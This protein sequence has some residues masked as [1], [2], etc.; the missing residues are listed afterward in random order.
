MGHA[1]LAL[2]IVAG[3]NPPVVGRGIGAA[4]GR[5]RL[6]ETELGGV[7]ATVALPGRG[8]GPWPGVLVYPGITARGRLHPGHQGIARGLASTG[9]ACAVAEPAGLA[10]GVVSPATLDQLGAAAVAFARHPA[11]RSGGLAVAGVSGGATLALLAAGASPAAGDVR[12]VL[13]LAPL[14]DFRLI[15]RAVST[16]TIVRGARTE[17]F[18]PAPLIRVVTARS[19]VSCL[20]SGGDRDALLEHLLDVGDYEQEPFAGLRRW[21]GGS[22]DPP[23][24]ALVTLLVN[25]DPAR[26]E[27]LF[28]ALDPSTREHVERLSP[29]T[30]AGRIRCPIDVVVPPDDKYIPLDDPLRFVRSCP[31]ARLVV[32]PALAHVIPRASWA[33]LVGMT[34]LE[35]SVARFLSRA[36]S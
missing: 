31:T 13:A 36:S 7:R 35:R 34:R 29:I 8:S 11:V 9:F 14:S 10:R 23:A 30:Y 27:E 1:R 26:F 6:R 3:A 4:A 32:T 15:L 24:R 19:M 17:R 12:A 22:L 2:A 16:G 5:P 21:D 25:E 18:A 20:P 28:A 33:G